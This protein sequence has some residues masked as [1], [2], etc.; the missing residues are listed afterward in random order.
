VGL[1]TVNDTDGHGAGD[2]LLRRVVAL[3]RGHLR[4]YDLVIRLGGDEFLCAMSNMT[5]ADARQRFGALATELAAAPGP[6]AI[7][8]G[9]AEF[10]PD[11]MATELIA[12]ADSELVDNRRASKARL[13]AT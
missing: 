5:L 13:A 3:V 12:R 10:A 4:P 8:T 7:R 11:Q 1:K 6:G 2:E 9:F